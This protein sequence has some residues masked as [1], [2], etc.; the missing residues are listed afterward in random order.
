MTCRQ[1]RQQIYRR[2]WF[3]TF[4]RKSWP[5]AT[6]I[7]RVRLWWRICLVLLLAWTRTPALFQIRQGLCSLLGTAQAHVACLMTQ[8]LKIQERGWEYEQIT[9]SNNRSSPRETKVLGEL[10]VNSCAAFGLW[11]SVH[12]WLCEY[13]AGFLSCFEIIPF[14]N[15]LFQWGEDILSLRAVVAI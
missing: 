1:C 14:P 15:Y 2:C 5:R 4:P 7:D 3:S 9:L 8:W 13:P 6:L 11:Q 10:N 12:C